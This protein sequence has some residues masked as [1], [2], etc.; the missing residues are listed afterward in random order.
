MSLGSWDPT[1]QEASALISIRPEWLQEFIALSQDDRLDA[2]AETLS[3]DL[4]TE[5]AGLMQ[6][7]EQAWLDAAGDLPDEDLWHLIRFFSVAEMQ[8][9]GWTAAHKSPAIPLARLLRQRGKPLDRDKLLWIRAHSDNR[10]IPN[11]K[12][13]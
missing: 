4:Q 13:L 3:D 11:G 12:L 2:L 5:R 1:T 7:P 10:F 6:L 8:L 9:S